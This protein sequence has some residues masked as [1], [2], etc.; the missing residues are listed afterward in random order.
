[1]TD[2]LTLC[3]GQKQAAY[4]EID[5]D[6]DLVYAK[7][8]AAARRAVDARYPDVA[9]LNGEEKFAHPDFQDH[10]HAYYIEAMVEPFL[11]ATW[12]GPGKPPTVGELGKSYMQ[13]EIIANLRAALIKN[14]AYI[15]MFPNVEVPELEPA[16]SNGG[17][18]DP[19][20]AGE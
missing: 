5:V 4:D 18:P 19:N 6:G 20:A 1:M 16:Q 9:A 8:R 13:S 2:T 15:H 12:A 7:A 17:S 3:K 10:D 11:R 14:P